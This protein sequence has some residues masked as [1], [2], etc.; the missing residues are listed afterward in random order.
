MSTRQPPSA[1]K[2]PQEPP[3]RSHK[4]AR[5]PHAPCQ[6]PPVRS[7]RGPPAAPAAPPAL[8]RSHA[9][10]VAE[11]ALFESGA[12]PPSPPHQGATGGSFWDGEKVRSRRCAS[13]SRLSRP[14]PRASDALCCSI[15]GRRRD[16]ARRRGCRRRRPDRPRPGHRRCARSRRRRPPRRPPGPRERLFPV[17]PRPRVTDAWAAATAACRERLRAAP[18]RLPLGRAWPG[19]HPR[20]RRRR[21]QPRRRVSAALA[22]SCERGWAVAKKI[23]RYV[24]VTSMVTVY[25]SSVLARDGV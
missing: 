10:G 11:S 23:S 12:L 17:W 7:G 6:P 18:R 14:V 25:R 19:G 4:G 16:Y 21:L 24:G 8:D 3:L 22:V 15:C 2:A 1:S 13:N 5:P 20:P 9:V